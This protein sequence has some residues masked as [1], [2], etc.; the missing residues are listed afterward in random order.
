MKLNIERFMPCREVL[1][2][3]VLERVREMEAA[4]KQNNK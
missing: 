2:E 4:R 1:T 3:K